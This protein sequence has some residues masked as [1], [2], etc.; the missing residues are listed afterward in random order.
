MHA[1]TEWCRSQYMVASSMSSALSSAKMSSLSI[2]S[3]REGALTKQLSDRGGS[4]Q[5]AREWRGTRAEASSQ[6]ARVT[7]GSGVR[8]GPGA[9]S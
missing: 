7:P 2:A 5:E 3:P 1:G 9:A 6:E 4:G 8:P